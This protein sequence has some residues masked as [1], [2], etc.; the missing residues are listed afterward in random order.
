MNI[1]G[2]AGGQPANPYDKDDEGIF[3]SK[4]N[5]SGTASRDGRLRPGMRIIEVNGA[6]LLGA[7][8][9]EAV[10]ALRN[11]GNRISLLVCDGYD[12]AQ[13]GPTS[14]QRYLA[15][16]STD[17]SN[18]TLTSPDTPLVGE[19]VDDDVFLKSHPGS[20]QIG[21]EQK[22]TTVIMKKHQTSSMVSS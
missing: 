18:S 1:K 4:I 3:I 6:S 22:T 16:G 20:P 9:Q 10:Q 17:L 21:K 7:G 14:G 15:A 5:P 8:H 19:F 2:G 13:S 11:A 12:P